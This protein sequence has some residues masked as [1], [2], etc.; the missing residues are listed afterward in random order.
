MK[1]KEFVVD[2]FE[3][4]SCIAFKI[5][6][7]AVRSIPGIDK[8]RFDSLCKESIEAIES[9]YPDSESA[10]APLYCIKDNPGLNVILHQKKQP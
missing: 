7:E 4:A 3:Q 8:D 1:E 9:M 5:L 2:G 10:A 6:S